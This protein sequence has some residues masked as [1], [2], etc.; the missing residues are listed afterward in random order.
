MLKNL[1]GVS[2]VELVKLVKVK[3][4]EASA[5]RNIS[6]PPRVLAPI[7]VDSMELSYLFFSVPFL[8][9]IHI[10]ILLIKFR[11]DRLPYF[12]PI[13]FRVLTLQAGFRFGFGAGSLYHFL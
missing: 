3:G 9:G 2:L 13:N 4:R 12:Q 11:F 1:L 8:S 5:S 10:G 7:A 6:S